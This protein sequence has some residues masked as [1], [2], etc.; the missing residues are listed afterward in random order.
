MDGQG[1]KKCFEFGGGFYIVEIERVALVVQKL[2]MFQKKNISQ[3]VWQGES[4][5]KKKLNISK[6]YF[7]YKY[8]IK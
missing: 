7:S 1:N 2:V 8:N 6:A 4:L 5:S 3:S